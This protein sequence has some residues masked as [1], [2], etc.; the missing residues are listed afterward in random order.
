VGS[1][2][3][4]EHAVLEKFPRVQHLVSRVE[5]RLAAGADAL[6]L[7]AACFPA[8]TVSGAPKVRALELV[9]ALE[10]RCRGPYAGAFGYFDGS[11]AAELAI[12]IRTLVVQK[13]RVH[14]QAGAGI[15]WESNPELEH[16]ETL[17][18]A[19]ALGETVA[20][21]AEPA[22]QPKGDKGVGGQS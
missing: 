21:A 6:D 4:C 17:H 15:V 11:G 14:W 1:V 10:G 8:G 3:V 22:F 18:K 19:Q 12:T 9:T 7:A 16:E 20:M 2:R 13:D 5:S